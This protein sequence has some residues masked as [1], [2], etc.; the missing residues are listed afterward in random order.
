MIL[1]IQKASISK[2]ISAFL[3][4]IIIIAIIAVGI[5]VIISTIVGYDKQVD[6]LDN[7][8]SEYEEKY[9]IDTNISADEYNSMSDDERERYDEASRLFSEDERV[10]KQFSLLMNLT[11]IVTSISIF[12]A[13][14]ISE[15]IV[16]L[17]LKNGQT[18][19]KKI[20][21]VAVMRIDGVKISA[22]QLFVRSILGKYTV[23]TMI[24]VFLLLMIYFE[25]IGFVGA[26]A[27]IL[28]LLLQVIFV[29]ATRTNSSLH[30]ML[31]VTVAVDMASQ[32]IFDSKEQ[33]E[34]YIAKISAEASENSRS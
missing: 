29:I 26:F 23:E 25:V 4:D 9:S 18:L 1:N 6:L 17:F 21:G 30:D 32:M 34:I 14:F 10:I 8:Y 20:F 16:P 33:K 22:F 31:A 19:G 2:R 27:I 7:F 15:F 12:V 11:V 13:F 5:A 24:P 28:I 3:F